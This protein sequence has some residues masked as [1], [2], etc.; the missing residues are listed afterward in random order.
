MRIVDWVKWNE[1]KKFNNETEFEDFKLCFSNTNYKFN[2]L[3]KIVID[4]IIKNKYCFCG[5]YHQYGEHG[6]PI[7]QFEN[8][9]YYY[10]TSMRYWGDIMSTAWNTIEGCDKYNYMDFYVS[11]SRLYG[12][13]KW[14]YPKGNSIL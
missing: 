8:K 1:D 13:E 6:I 2:D 12:P 14:I 3:D 11:Y 4:E 5:D 7:I 10:L 9:K